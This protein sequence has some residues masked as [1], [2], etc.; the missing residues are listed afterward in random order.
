MFAAEEGQWQ[1]AESCRS[2]RVVIISLRRGEAYSCLNDI[3]AELSP[4]VLQLAP[5]ASRTAPRSIP[6]QSLAE[7]A[8]H[9]T[10]VAQVPPLTSLCPGM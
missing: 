6:F 9:R 10:L 4:A 1:V 7:G 5:L 3:K 8:G 2:Q